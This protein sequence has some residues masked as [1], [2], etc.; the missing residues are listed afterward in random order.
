MKN[1]F[2]RLREF[3]ARGE[4]SLTLDGLRDLLGGLKKQRLSSTARQLNEVL[5]QLAQT[6]R[7]AQAHR[8]NRISHENYERELAKIAFSVLELIDEIERS[9]A[10]QLP[11]TERSIELPAGS[12]EKIISP[13]SQ[14]KSLAW[15]HQGLSSAQSVCRVVGPSGLGTGFVIPG[16]LLLTNNHVLAT[17]TAASAAH[18]EFNFE[19][20]GFG[21]L[22]PS[23]DFVLDEADFLTS[24]RLDC[25]A[26]KIREKQVGELQRWGT[27]EIATTREIEIEEHVTIIQHPRGGPK[28][29][30][31]TENKVVN[32]FNGRLQYT[33]DTMPGSSGSP[34]FNDR[35]QVVAIHH[36]GGNLVTNTRG[37]RIFANQGIL[38]KAVLADTEFRRFLLRD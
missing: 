10:K 5:V 27:L 14:L 34:V 38:L 17:S 36:A 6:T 13:V 15:L 22:Q 9:G 11:V 20:D 31:L 1:L 18:I 32:I 4:V 19:E 24:E 33:T 8:S 28:Q 30:C 23:V 37:D 2:F 26:V 3:V 35:W 12:F 21:K 25:T 7:L 29:I 16:G